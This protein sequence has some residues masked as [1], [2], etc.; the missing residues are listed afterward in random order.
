VEYFK[1]DCPMP[2]LAQ[3][4]TMLGEDCSNMANM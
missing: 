2:K 4:K 1:Q 3:L